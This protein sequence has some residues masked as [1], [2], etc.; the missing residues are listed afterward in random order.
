MEDII[1]NLRITVSDKLYKKDPESSELG[2]RIIGQGILLIDEIGFENFTFRKL[3]EKISSNESSIY[4]Y[5]ENKHNF[6]VY[7]TAWFWGWKEFQLILS[8]NN[9]QDP[10]TKLNT[11]VEVMTYP[12]EEDIRFKHIDEVAL[13]NIIIN[14][15]S[16]SFLTKD[17]DA[18]NKEGFFLIYKR[19]V[20]RI[21]EMI[22]NTDP[23][24]DF[25]FNLATSIIDGSL[26]QHFMSQHFPTITDCKNGITPSAFYK[27]M[28]SQI[29]NT[30]NGRQ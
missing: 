2:K 6:L 15:S 5:F 28:I 8:T 7:I 3:G 26:H 21:S 24:Y 1:K 14:E 12:V 17:V 13:N 20:K 23:D 16:K 19:L 4:R 29:L 25:P 30:H 11:A 9:I 10:L 22:S 27:N 18:D